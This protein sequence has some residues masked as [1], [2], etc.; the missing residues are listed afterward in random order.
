MSVLWIG[1]EVEEW[2]GGSDSERSEVWTLL[3]LAERKRIGGM[4]CPGVDKSAA[5]ESLPSE[6]EGATKSQAKAG[7]KPTVLAN[8]C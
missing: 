2:I 4:T 8:R 1:R 7:R 3:Q 5:Y 6:M